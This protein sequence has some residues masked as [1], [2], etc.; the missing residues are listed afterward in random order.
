MPAFRPPGCAPPDRSSDVGVPVGSR[1]GIGVEAEASG[2]GGP[3]EPRRRVPQREDPIEA[4]PRGCVVPGSGAAGSFSAPWRSPGASC[5]PPMRVGRRGRASRRPPGGRRSAPGRS[6]HR[7]DCRWRQ[8]WPS[9]AWL[10]GQ[11]RGIGGSQPH[12]EHHGGCGDDAGGWCAAEI[13]SASSDFDLGARAGHPPRRADRRARSTRPCS[14]HGDE[15]YPRPTREP[16]QGHARRATMSPKNA[17]NHDSDLSEDER[18]I[19]RRRSRCRAAPRGTAAAITSVAA[20]APRSCR[21]D[22]ARL[23]PGVP[24]HPHEQQRHRQDHRAR[25]TRPRRARIPS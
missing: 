4:R 13:I 10:T 23:D 16:Q 21:R 22:A 9:G 20:A 25:R 7:R 14:A 11:P 15:P 12:R 1:R 17:R 18:N 2:V 5:V 24:A 6:P 3:P 19:P 8:A